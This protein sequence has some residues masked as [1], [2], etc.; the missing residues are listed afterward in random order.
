MKVVKK[1]GCP[2]LID[3]QQGADVCQSRLGEYLVETIRR[4]SRC[5]TA[6]KTTTKGLVPVGANGTFTRQG[7]VNQ[8]GG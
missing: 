8:E 6:A 3:L 2:V 7:S 4:D 5:Q 1:N